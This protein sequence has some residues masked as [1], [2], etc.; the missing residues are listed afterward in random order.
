MGIQAA[1]EQPSG[2]RE[3]G[4]TQGRIPFLLR[5][6]VT[7]HRKIPE[8]KEL[9][10]AVHDAIDLAISRSGYPGADR[11]TPLK[12]T[13]VSALAEGADR[14]VAL[15][16]LNR[17]GSLVC[18]L[19]VVE[20]DL[21]LYRADFESEKSRQEFDDLCSR[22]RQQIEPPERLPPE[23]RDAGYLWAGQEVARNSDVIIAIWDGQ[24]SRGVGGTA[25]LIRRLRHRDQE[26]RPERAPE[27]PVLAESGPLRIIVDIS[28]G[29]APYVFVDEEP[30]YDVAA[31]AAQDRLRSDWAGLHTFNH[32]SFKPADWQRWTEQMMEGLAPARYRQWP[33][34]NYL[35]TQITPP[36]TRADQEAI[37]AQ[38]AFRW[39]S[40]ALFG[41]T[42]LATILAALQAIIFT[43]TWELA[44][45]ELVLIIATVIIVTAERGWKNN[46]KHWFVYRFLAERLRT[47]FYLLAVGCVPDTD[48]DVGGTTEEPTQNDWVRRAFTEILADSDPEKDTLENF[49]TMSSLIR[50]HW[51]AGQLRYFERTSK[52]MMRRHRTVRGLLYGVLGATIVA[53]LLHSL[54]IWPFHS[55]ATEALIMCAIGLPAVA[56]A[57]SN[58]RSLREFSRHAFRYTRMAA[59]I[60]SYLD[61][62][63]EEPSA[64]DIAV[65]AKKV[66]NLLTAETRGWLVEVS[67]HGIELDG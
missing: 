43:G 35:L 36:L 15:E 60:R 40:Y 54:R 20:K 10:K 42:A 48:F 28:A 17:N 11:H 47:T 6:G 56:A 29:H 27:E 50:A 5:I 23:Q 12:L 39:S 41:S 62:F 49:E 16:V 4:P 45:G 44:V 37:A 1:A 25:D 8:G 18:V 59:V 67:A 38:R 57:L 63:G 64:D 2:A 53:A 55:G 32:R 58:V 9:L 31:A 51:M 30:P 24:A 3:D 13:V 34:L 19:P 14:L 65:V 52:K 21:D 26:R 61:E 22:A 66:G 33:R 46:N 7:G